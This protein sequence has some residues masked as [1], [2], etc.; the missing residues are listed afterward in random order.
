MAACRAGEAREEEVGEE[1]E[2]GDNEGSLPPP[3]PP[4]PATAPAALARPFCCKCELWREEEEE[5][6]EREE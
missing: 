4:P 5:V 1:E 6:A 3:P 2:K